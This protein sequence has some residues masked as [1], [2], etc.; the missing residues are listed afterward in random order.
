MVRLEQSDLGAIGDFYEKQPAFFPL[1]AA[2]LRGD[3]D[4][5]VMCDRPDS[6]QA[7]YAEH[8]FGFAQVFGSIDCNFQ[9]ILQERL[10]KRKSFTA[11]KIRLYTPEEP[12]FLREMKYDSI[13]SE[14]QRFISVRTVPLI[15]MGSSSFELRTLEPEHLP[16]ISSELVDV[17]RFWRTTGEFVDCSSAIVAWRGTTAVAIC[18]AAAIAANRAE[19]DV[20][21]L[22][23]FRRQ[24]LGTAV[25]L[26]FVERCR[27]A[28]V[29]PLWDCFTNN[30]GSM[31]L[32]RTCGFQPTGPAY[33]FYTIPR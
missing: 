22:P 23:D 19:I 32:A 18:Y 31:A 4:G 27:S 24:G 30:A 10:V 17:T 16:L 14:R 5:E 29:V 3:Q 8:S 13:R 9:A 6:P 1:I 26:A 2:V 33:S 20:A 21:T 15:P 11:K 7:F 25:V 28:G 12:E